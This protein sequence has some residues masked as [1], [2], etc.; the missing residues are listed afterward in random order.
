M[1]GKLQLYN[2]KNKQMYEMLISKIGDN[3]QRQTPA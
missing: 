3:K 2:A 1:T